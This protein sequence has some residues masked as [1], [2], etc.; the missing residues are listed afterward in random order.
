MD[1]KKPYMTAFRESLAAMKKTTARMK[2]ENLVLLTEDGKSAYSTI[3]DDA[4][5]KFNELLDGR[6]YRTRQVVT[7]RIRKFLDYARR[8][9]EIPGVS[10][11][12]LVIKQN[13]DRVVPTLQ[14]YLPFKHIVNRLPVEGV[15]SLQ[16]FA[17]IYNTSDNAPSIIL[18]ACVGNPDKFPVWANFN[19]ELSSTMD[20]KKLPALY[21]EK[22]EQALA[23]R[24]EAKKEHEES[25]KTNKRPRRSKKHD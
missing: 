3:R 4:V 23:K 7:K 25:R 19:E 9:P 1:N 6:L 22:L 20:S 2:R 8:I 14:A 24:I 18:T 15:L 11:G 21:Q 10:V 16:C 12:E 17:D 13:T 5:A